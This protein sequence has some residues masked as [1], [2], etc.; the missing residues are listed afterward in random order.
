MPNWSLIMKCNRCFAA[1]LCSLLLATAFASAGVKVTVA[2]NDAEHSTADFKFKDVPAPAKVS[3]ATA[4]KFRVVDGEKDDAGGDLD[5]L[6]DGKLP[7]EADLPAANFFFN[8]GTEGGRLCIDL[9]VPTDVKQINTY[10]WHPDT[11]APQVY[12]LYGAEGNAPKFNSSPS[13][14]VDPTTCGW[15]LIAKVDTRPKTGDAG[16]QYGVSISDT[17]GLVGKFRYLLLA[18]TPTETDDAFGNTF[19]SEIS[20]VSS[21]D[22]AEML[23]APK[24]A[25]DQPGVKQLSIEH[26]KYTVTVDTTETPDLTDWAN[27]QLDPVVIEWYPKLVAMLPSDGYSAPTH[28][29]ITFRADKPGEKGWVANTGGTRI[30]CSHAFY[31]K[32]LKGEAIGSIIHEMVHVVQQYGAFRANRPRRTNT[33]G[34]LTEGIPDYIRWYKFEPKAGGADISKRGYDKAR[35]DGMYRIS[36]NFLNYVVGKYDKD[37]IR[38]VNAA[39][40]DG[41]YTDDLFPKLTGKSLDELN[42][43][44][45]ADLARKLGIAPAN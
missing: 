13:K 43:E 6:H 8:Q 40:R 5:V 27:N 15:K 35:Y 24:P 9:G 31:I 34:W 28:F 29:S 21:G 26:G 16:G 42:T 37:L 18:A 1:F 39:L 20:V 23:T 45:K 19:F 3:A 14:D 41:T 36:A 32:Q 7:T 33:P 22:A 12:T 2:H 25:A 30:N 4:A 10:S 44:W 11:R 17:T 38:E